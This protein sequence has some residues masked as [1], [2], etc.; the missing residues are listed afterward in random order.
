MNEPSTHEQLT[1][2]FKDLLTPL[3]AEKIAG[4]C[5]DIV[6]RERMKI[7]SLKS[8]TDEQMGTIALNHLRSHS[9][10]STGEWV[11]PNPHDPSQK[12]IE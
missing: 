2:E 4:Q 12:S 5:A 1:K 9:D 6:I 7:L 10:K 8:L 3:K 11:N